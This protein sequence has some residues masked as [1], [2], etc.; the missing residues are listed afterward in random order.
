MK[1]LKTNAFLIVGFFI[2]FTFLLSAL[3]SF[4]YSYDEA[5]KVNLSEKFISPGLTYFMGTDETGASLFKKVLIGARISLFI[6][7]T[8][9]F[10]GLI[11]GTIYGAVSG[12]FGGKLDEFMMRALDLLYS[13][14]GFLL[15]LTLVCVLGPSLMNLII[16]LSL[17]SWTG[18][19]R[20]VRGEVLYLKELDYVSS[21]KSIGSSD[22]RI[23]VFYILPNL[24]GILLVQSTFSLAGTLII[25][26]GLSF[27]GLGAPAHIPTW[28]ALLNSGKFYLLEAFHI[29]FFPGVSI[30]LVVLGF[31]LLGDG[32]KESLDP[33][34][35]SVV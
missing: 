22:L 9:V 25:E 3:W 16:A 6:A 24:T 34:K 15:A 26:S 12:Y 18:F 21:A 2:I 19:A 1:K 30:V 33:K 5:N 29:S 4:T 27:L 20:L 10:I 7:F 11:L 17:T 14:P 31:N 32:L 35:N 13:F 28:G 8:V 23:L